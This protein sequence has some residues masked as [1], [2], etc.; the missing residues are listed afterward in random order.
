VQELVADPLVSQR[1]AISLMKVILSARKPLAAY[2]ISSEV[3]RE[4]KTMGVSFR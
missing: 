3:R 1:S 2:L 4:V